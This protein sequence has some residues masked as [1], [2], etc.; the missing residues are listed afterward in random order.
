MA[1]LLCTYLL[2]NTVGF[3]IYSHFCGSKLVETAFFDESDSCCKKPKKDCCSTQVAAVQ[4]I[5]QY[6]AKKVAETPIVAQNQLLDF[7]LPTPAFSFTPNFPHTQYQS[8]L[9]YPDISVRLQTFRI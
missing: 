2:F 6:V 5:E 3:T 9:L 8:V 4:F 7:Y 1:I